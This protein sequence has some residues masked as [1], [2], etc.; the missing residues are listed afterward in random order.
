MVGHTGVLIDVITF[1][2]LHLNKKKHKYFGAFY[3]TV[4][5]YHEI[6][7]KLLVIT[8]AGQHSKWKDL[9]RLAPLTF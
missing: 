4:T 9:T 6:E 2:A 5:L 3:L 1:L 8:V 7:N